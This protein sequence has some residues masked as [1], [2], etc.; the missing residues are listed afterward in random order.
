MNDL[1]S[2][3]HL[4]SY[5]QQQQLNGSGQ[6]DSKPFESSL[7]QSSGSHNRTNSNKKKSK[8][9]DPKGFNR[10][11]I[12][13]V[14]EEGENPTAKFSHVQSSGY[15][16]AKNYSSNTGG[17]RNSIAGGDL[18][19]SMQSSGSKGA[20]RVNPGSLTKQGFKEDSSSITSP[21]K[22]PAND[23]SQTSPVKQHSSPNKTSQQPRFNDKGK[24]IEEKSVDKSESNSLN[25]S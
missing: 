11:S 5:I 18:N 10:E 17:N 9:R 19:S 20:S 25:N 6:Q 12:P 21:N 2:S 16:P 22:R 1:N 8:A 3:P 24:V 14:E 15:G 7:R 23:R 4:M 13:E